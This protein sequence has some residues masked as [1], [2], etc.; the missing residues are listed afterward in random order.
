M[1]LTELK[2]QIKQFKK[3]KIDY[4][5]YYKYILLNNTQSW[6]FVNPNNCK[7]SFQYAGNYLKFMVFKRLC[8]YGYRLRVYPTRYENWTKYEYVL[9][10][11]C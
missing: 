7:K 2:N 1:N 4:K 8:K 10:Y 3:V 5:E 11:S 9:E 6:H